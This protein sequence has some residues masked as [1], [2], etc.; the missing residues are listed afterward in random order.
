MTDVR[1]LGLVLNLL[2]PIIDSTITLHGP[3]PVLFPS[4]AN[5]IWSMIDTP[6]PK[7][8]VLRLSSNLG[9]EF[10]YVQQATIIK[11]N[12]IK[13]L[14]SFIFK[15]N[16]DIMHTVTICFKIFVIFL[17]NI[18]GFTIHYCIHIEILINGF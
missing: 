8:I 18:V 16:S 6:F 10:L 1:V 17:L 9:F 15:R 14:I 4:Q 13:I 7:K 2:I 3:L 12:R 5:M 11:I